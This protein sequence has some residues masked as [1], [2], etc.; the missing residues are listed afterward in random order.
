MDACTQ[1]AHFPE[2]TLHV[3]EAGGAKHLVYELEKVVVVRYRILPAGDSALRRY[4]GIPNLDRSAMLEEVTFG[5]GRV[6]WS[7]A[8]EDDDED[9][10]RR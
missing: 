6:T 9:D 7:E 5:Y 2:V 10:W 1:G 8:D 3:T 4:V